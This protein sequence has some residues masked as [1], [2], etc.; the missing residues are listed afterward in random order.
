MEQNKQ[1]LPV[2]AG[3]LGVGDRAQ[4]PGVLPAEDPESP[5]APGPRSRQGCETGPQGLLFV[6]SKKKKKWLGTSQGG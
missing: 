2:Q 5:D 6:S 4:S 1:W 3:F